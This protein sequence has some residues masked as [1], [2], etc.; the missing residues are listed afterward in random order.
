MSTVCVHFLVQIHSLSE[1]VPQEPLGRAYCVSSFGKLI[2][3]RELLLLTVFFV[4]L[5]TKA[6]DAR[7]EDI[8]SLS[9]C[10]ALMIVSDT[11]ERCAPNLHVRASGLILCLR[12]GGL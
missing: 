4:Q 11:P 7:T 10:T 8:V 12:A 2:C 1:D 9:A 3:I 6:K 5:G